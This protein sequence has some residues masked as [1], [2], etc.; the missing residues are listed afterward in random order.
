MEIFLDHHP[1]HQRLRSAKK[2]GSSVWYSFLSLLGVLGLWHLGL[3]FIDR[4]FK[5]NTL[6]WHLQSLP[7]LVRPIISRRATYEMLKPQ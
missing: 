7:R 5:L 6:E 3:A 2:K 1:S 4:Y